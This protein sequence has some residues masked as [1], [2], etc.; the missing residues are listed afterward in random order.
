M[1]KEKSGYNR[2]LMSGFT[3][4]KEVLVLTYTRKEFDLESIYNQITDGFALENEGV[5]KLVTPVDH[6][7]NIVIMTNYTIDAFA[8]SDRHRLWF[9]PNSTYYCEHEKLTVKTPACC[10]DR[11]FSTNTSGTISSWVGF[12]TT[13][14]YC[15][16]QYLKHVLK[17]FEVTVLQKSQPSRS[18]MA[19]RR[20]WMN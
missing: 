15:L 12:Y 1:K 5:A 20:F 9:V 2:L 17:K 8:R 3:P 4:R 6:V 19:T 16:D 13:C 7:P 18:F 10:H 11:R 14:V